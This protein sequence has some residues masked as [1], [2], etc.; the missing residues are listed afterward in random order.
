MHV[1]LRVS[2]VDGVAGARTAR[3][4]AVRE[5]SAETVLLTREREP[6]RDAGPAPR[7]CWFPLQKMVM[8]HARTDSDDEHHARSPVDTIGE[9]GLLDSGS[10]S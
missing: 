3:R 2:A 8:A 5:V 1:L 9:L 10:L 7:C 4:G 6:A